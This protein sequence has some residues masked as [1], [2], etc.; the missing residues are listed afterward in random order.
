MLQLINLSLS[1]GGQALLRNLNW[2]LRKG[3]RVGLVGPNGAGKTTLFRLII[4]QIEPDV[5]TVQRGRAVTIGYL[6]QE[7]IT[8]AGRSLFAETRSALPQLTDIQ[9]ELSVIHAALERD[10]VAGEEHDELLARYGDLQHRFEELGGFRAD[11]EVATVLTGLGFHEDQFERRTETFSGGWQMRIALAKLLLQQPDILLLDEP[12]N[13]L[14]LDSLLWLEGYLK[15]YRGSIVIISHDREFLD[16]M[17]LRIA[18]LHRGTLSEYVGNYSAFERQFERE[19][20]AYHKAYEEQQA[21]IERIKKFIDTFRYNARKASQVQSRVKQL[22]KMERLE[23]PQGAPKGVR[24]HFPSAPR[25]GRV[26]LELRGIGKRYGDLQ[27]FRNLDLIV[28]RGDRVALVGVNGAGKS[29]LSRILAGVE[30][31]TEGERR[32][33]YQVMLDYYAQQQADRL[34][35]ESTVYQEIARNARLEMVPELRTLLGAFLFSGD[36][37]EKKVGV[38]SGGEKSRLALAKMLLQPSNLLILDEPTNH[39]DIRTKDVLREA[40]LQFGGTFVIASHD[41]YFLKGLATKV[42]EVRDGQLAMYPGTFEEFLQWKEQ[43]EGSE[44]RSL[45]SEVPGSKS[46]VHTPQSVVT[47][48]QSAVRTPHSPTDVLAVIE[49]AKR[50]KMTYARQKAAR[51]ERQ[52][53][54]R[55]LGDMEQHIAR[56]EERKAALEA[57]MADGATFGDPQRARDLATEYDTLKHELEERYATW[58]ELAEAMDE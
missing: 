58:T 44:G 7:G 18:A 32:L 6:P 30:N 9:D 37:V 2:H 28:E 3:D 50:G 12:T 36:T 45:K 35:G 48:L 54:E 20:E 15:A 47:N 31:P 25:S 16:R 41:R 34:Q 8:V 27:V 17:V 19:V 55:R 33:G 52:K 43:R 29:T 1:F 14:D 51:A 10:G 57:L 40:L 39:L 46:A 42:L 23:A 5:G 24:F 22:E 38:L 13:H 56:L 21:E 11:A 26:V 4:G 49:E 53:R